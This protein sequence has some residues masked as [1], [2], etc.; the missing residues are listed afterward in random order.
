MEN[1]ICVI[2]VISYFPLC[3]NILGELQMSIM[4][5]HLHINELLQTNYLICLNHPEFNDSISR[6]SVHFTFTVYFTE[7][8]LTEDRLYM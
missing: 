3:Y 6:I 7:R 2:S 1:N 4:L 8:Q 5:L